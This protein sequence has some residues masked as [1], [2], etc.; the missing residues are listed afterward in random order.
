MTVVDKALFEVFE[1]F[2]VFRYGTDTSC[3]WIEVL[4]DFLHMKIVSGQLIFIVISH[5]K[6]C[7]DFISNKQMFL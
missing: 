1:K 3:N 6:M 5:L 7:K 4:V 2:I